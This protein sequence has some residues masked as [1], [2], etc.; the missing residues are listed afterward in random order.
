M[1]KTTLSLAALIL[2]LCFCFSACSPAKAPS[3][4]APL[5]PENLDELYSDYF[6][7]YFHPV[8]WS[9]ITASSWSDPAELDPRHFVHYYTA[10]Q[11]YNTHNDD[12]DW[13]ELPESV[14]AQELE[15][16][17]LSHFDVSTELLRSADAYDPEK[18]VYA[19]E[20]MGGASSARVVDA[21]LEGDLLL[22][23]FEYYSPADDVTVTRSGTLQ[24]RVG[25]G[26]HQYLS[27]VS[28]ATDA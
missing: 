23:T 1:K 17:V 18:N 24:L 4:S 5:D 20:Y 28:H 27:C 12:K 3:S 6:H 9:S 15:D 8:F 2:C 19:I 21:T 22:L 11:Y 10:A 13:T 7:P 16:F 26:T 25:N 14:P